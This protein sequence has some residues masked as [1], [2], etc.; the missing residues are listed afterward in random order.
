MN[1]LVGRYELIPVKRNLLP[2][3]VRM[4]AMAAGRTTKQRLNII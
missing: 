1:S 2:L 3:N 4:Q